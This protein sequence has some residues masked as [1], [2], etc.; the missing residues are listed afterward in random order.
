MDQIKFASILT[1]V[2]SIIPAVTI[3]GNSCEQ[4]TCREIRTLKE[5]PNEVLSFV[6]NHPHGLLADRGGAFNIT[7]LIDPSLPMRRFV[8]AGMMRDRLAVEI[9]RGGRSH[10]FQTLHFQ[11][12]DNLW[13]Y[14]STEDFSEEVDNLSALLR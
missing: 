5:L 1:L 14:V 4:R 2:L 6:L 8:V 11:R 3:A 9:E 13:V 7:D 12:V 10:Y